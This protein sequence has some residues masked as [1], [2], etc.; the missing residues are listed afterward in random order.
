MARLIVSLRFPLSLALVCLGLALTASFSTGV[1]FS[2]TLNTAI[3]IG[4]AV[5]AWA[6]L[7]A[8]NVPL[9]SLSRAAIIFY[10]YIAVALFWPV[11]YPQIA[12]AVRAASFQTPDIF[13]KANQLVAI[14]LATMLGTW[15]L[16]FDLHVRRPTRSDS[17]ERLPLHPSSFAPLMLMA[18]PLFVL[19]FP[20]ASIFTVGYN[21]ASRDVTVGASV[22]INV[23]KPALII[24]LLFALVALL[25]RPTAWRKIFWGVSLA[26]EVLILGFAV[27]NRV[28][29]LGCLLAVG[30]LFQDHQPGRHFPKRGVAAA[31]FLIFVMLVLGEI[32]N[33]L[34]SEPFNTT[35]LLDATRRALQIIP[36]SDTLKMR[37]STN[38]DI[39]ATICVV[40]GLVDTGVLEIDHG[41]TFAKY[42][43]MTLPRFLNPQR[44]TELQVLLQQLGMTGGGLFVLAEPYLAGGAVGVFVVMGL[45][46]FVI[47]TLEVRF[48]RRAL[49]PTG[50]ILY[51]L[52]LSCTP[53]W[54][55]YSFLTM[56]KHVLTGI[57]ILVLSACFTR[58]FERQSPLR[59]KTLDY[60]GI[61]S[62]SKP[63]VLSQT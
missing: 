35:L 7:R 9:V 61:G 20:T 53:R 30:W 56:Y 23:L 29:E 17:R 49:S 38:G 13:A 32:R 44:P 26:A 40:I 14:A 39:A 34:P 16:A 31:V 24:C 47:G 6:C 2:G 18:L 11:V 50:F 54:F 63:K 46:G 62:A 28:E 21:G 10:L 3:W 25:Q 59:V 48:V 45:V 42:G 33:I 37:P 58:F 36:Q 19:T 41:E 52:L 57:V 5:V 4:V 12:I 51:L 43:S 55:L 22:D 60:R 8:H 1:V 15:L 27:G